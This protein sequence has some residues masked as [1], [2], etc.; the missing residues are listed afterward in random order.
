[1]EGI[2]TWCIA[3]IWIVLTG[4]FWS[5]VICVVPVKRKSFNQIWTL[6]ILLAQS[7]SCCLSER[8]GFQSNLDYLEIFGPK[9]VQIAPVKGKDF[10]HI[11]TI[12]KLLVQSD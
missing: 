6:W 4:L 3:I 8:K 10:S 11:W 2:P 5:K 12:L 7:G 9:G 1:M